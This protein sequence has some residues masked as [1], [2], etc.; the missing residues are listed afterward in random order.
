MA[1][2]DLAVFI[3]HKPKRHGADL[4][5]LLQLKGH[6]VAVVLDQEDVFVSLFNL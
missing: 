3:S 1:R 4:R 2:V 5:E 6:V